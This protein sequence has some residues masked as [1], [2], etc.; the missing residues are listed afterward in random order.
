MEDFLAEIISPI[1]EWSI[2]N[3][4]PSKS[5][6]IFA[7]IAI[8]IFAIP[9]ILR[10][11][12]SYIT[13]NSIEKPSWQFTIG[14]IPLIMMSFFFAY[15]VHLFTVDGDMPKFIQQASRFTDTH[16]TATMI[17]ILMIFASII[18]LLSYLKKQSKE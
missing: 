8:P 11:F 2:S 15:H 1:Y 5:F 7:L 13:N 6:F 4:G 16:S 14:I 12:A 18:G 10:L 3:F 9:Y 17:I